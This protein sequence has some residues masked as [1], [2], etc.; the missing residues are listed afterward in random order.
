MPTFHT[1]GPWTLTDEPN[2]LVA[3]AD[4]TYVA[5]VFAYADG[6]TGTLRGNYAADAALIASAPDL[7]AALQALLNNVVF[8][9]V[10]EEHYKHWPDIAAARAALA[11][12]TGA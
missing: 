6:P 10:P 8:H 2:P 9:N 5:Q 12:A 7:L 1:P 3:G 11:R 4:G